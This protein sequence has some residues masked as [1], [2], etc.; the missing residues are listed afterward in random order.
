MGEVFAESAGWKAAPSMS[1]KR[2]GLSA[3]A[4]GGSIF[5]L[6]GG[7]NGTL[8]L[9]TVESFNGSWSGVPALSETLDNTAAAC[10]AEGLLYVVGG[11]DSNG[12]SGGVEGATTAVFSLTKGAQ[13]RSVAMQGPIFA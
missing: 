4:C 10:S 1:H 3:G 6:G 5:A 12:T 9:S 13:Q 11:Y 2:A 7:D 8:G